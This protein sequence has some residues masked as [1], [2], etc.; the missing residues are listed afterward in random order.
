MF[1]TVVYACVKTA[2][3]AFVWWIPDERE[4]MANAEAIVRTGSKESSGDI[5]GDDS[6]G[7]NRH[8]QYSENEAQRAHDESGSIMGW[9]M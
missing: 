8:S 3:S 6:L 7:P 9:E 1:D 4:M 5:L 2:E